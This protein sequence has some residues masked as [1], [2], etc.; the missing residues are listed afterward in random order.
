[1]GRYKDYRREPKR[2]GYDDDQGSEHPPFGG[3][4]N[5]PSPLAPRA[6]KPVEAVVK[7]FNAEKGFGFVSVVGG[8]DAFLHIRQLEAAGHSSVPEGARVKVRIGQGQ[9]G[10]QVA[11]VLEVNLRAAPS[12]TSAGRRPAMQSQ[13]RGQTREST[14]TVKM[15]TAEKGFGFVRQEGGGQD[16]FVHATT[17]ARAGLSR[18]VEGQRVRMQIEQGQKGLQAQTIEILD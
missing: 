12:G 1:M 18:L 10:P 9:K 16:V 8:P 4:P 6:S 7:R 13:V 15:Y 14:G 2:D 17:L 5:H 3:R 11:E